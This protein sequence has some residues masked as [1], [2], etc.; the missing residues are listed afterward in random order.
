MNIFSIISAGVPVVVQPMG[1]NI[2][3]QGGPPMG[4]NMYP[5]LGQPVAANTGRF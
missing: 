4:S 5:Q 1:T 2:Y 3:Q